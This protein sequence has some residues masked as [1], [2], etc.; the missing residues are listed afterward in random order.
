MIIFSIV[1]LNNHDDVLNL[2]LILETY[3]DIFTESDNYYI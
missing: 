2:P 3:M 1:D